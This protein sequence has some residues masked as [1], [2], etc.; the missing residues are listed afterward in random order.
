MIT[1]F[2]RILSSWVVLAMLAL[3]LVAFVITG[4]NL[5]GG[6]SIGSLGGDASAPARIGRSD[7]PAKDLIQRTQSEFEAAQ[8]QSP[9]LTLTQFV[10]GGGVE[11]TVEQMINLRAIESFAN[12]E[13]IYASKRLIDGEIA[14]IPAFRGVTGTFDRNIFLGIIQQQRLTEGGVR[15]DIAREKIATMVAVPASAAVRVPVNLATP[16]AAALLERREGLVVSVPASAI[17]ATKPAT[18]AE[19]QAYYKQ[20]VARYTAPETR[21]IRLARFDRAR[22]AGKAVPSEAEIAT[23]YKANAAKYAGKETRVLIQAILPDQAAAAALVAKVKAGATLEAAAKAAGSEANRLGEQDKAAYARFSNAA[24]ADA[25]FGA[26]QGAIAGPSKSGLGWHVIRVDKI[27]RTSGKTLADVRATLIAELTKA[28]TDG[29]LAD[30][31]T[32][33]EDSINDGATFDDVVKA[34]GLT[35]DVTPAVTADGR[36]PTDAKFGFAPE[37]APILRDAFQAEVEDDASVI[38]IKPGEVYA[39]YDLDRINA[40]APRPIAQVLA[41]IRADLEQTR[42]NAAARTVAAAV[43][44]KINKGIAVADAVRS[45]GVTLPAPK[46]IAARQLEL[47]QAGGAVPPTLETLFRIG[48]KQARL[49]ESPEK[50]GWS[51][52]YLEKII[53]ATASSQPG[54]IEL[55]Q[56]QMARSISAELDAQFANAMKAAVNATR[57]PDAIA[58]IKRDLAGA[59]AQ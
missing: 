43:A 55:T 9:G 41:Q 45:S 12:S 25:A 42:A 14:S 19:I 39:L 3:I 37:V 49:I 20:N 35:A 33:I 15:D 22:F 38:S 56:T 10:R 5:P 4:I 8:R 32:K 31:I 36:S 34:E 24:T 40:A 44:A 27:A 59:S 2:R 1:F 30:F 26:A 11:Q 6:G 18:D 57:H 51:V 23:A 7:L 17:P 29:L 47:A 46:P 52:V 48:R 13:G 54:I 21:S 58:K 28:K 16:Y 50:N 53:A